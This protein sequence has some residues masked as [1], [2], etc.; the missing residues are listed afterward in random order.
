[1]LQSSVQGLAFPLRSSN[2]HQLMQ[3]GTVT[4]QRT[5]VHSW[6]SPDIWSFPRD[7]EG[8][9]LSF[10]GHGQKV[11]PLNKC[12][13]KHRKKHN[14]HMRWRWD[15]RSISIGMEERVKFTSPSNLVQPGS[16]RTHCG[17]SWLKDPHKTAI[18]A[19]DLSRFRHA[20][21]Q[22][23]RHKKFYQKKLWVPTDFNWQPSQDLGS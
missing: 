15:R 9:K 6:S 23:S 1:M 14:L 21:K 17:Q 11:Y 2:G 3:Q 13:K 4:S 22:T 12:S 10:L 20:Q 8:R 18:N 19:T 5:W 7:V 16:L